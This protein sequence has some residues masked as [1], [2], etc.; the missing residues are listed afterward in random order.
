MIGLLHT[1][2]LTS[3][4]LSWADRIFIARPH[5]K[6]YKARYWYSRSVH[7]FVCLS[8]RL[9]VCHNPMFCQNG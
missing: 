3:W 6:L 5:A 8:V 4:Q 7:L 1:I 9:S 2:Q